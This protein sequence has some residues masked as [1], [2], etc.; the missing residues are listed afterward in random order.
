MKRQLI[1]VI[2]RRVTRKRD[3]R[4]RSPNPGTNGRLSILSV[5]SI[6][7]PEAKYPPADAH[8]LWVACT[9]IGRDPDP[10]FAPP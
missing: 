9:D 5:R 1:A 4:D 10:K 6:E 7:T 3:C 8:A 2:T